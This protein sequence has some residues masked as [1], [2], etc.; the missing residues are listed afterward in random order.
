M[1]I[2]LHIQVSSGLGR[3]WGQ[4]IGLAHDA[5]YLAI[6]KGM[7]LWGNAKWDQRMPQLDKSQ[8]QRKGLH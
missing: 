8:A 5:D 6:T 2:Y 4:Q 7:L 1:R 3:G